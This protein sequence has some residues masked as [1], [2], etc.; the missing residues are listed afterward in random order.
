MTHADDNH[1]ARYTAVALQSWKQAIERLHK[2][3][4]TL[5]EDDLQ[6]RV[7]PGKNRIYYLIGHLAAV[8][9][10]MFPLLGLGERVHPELDEPFLAKP[11]GA[12]ADTLSAADLRKAYADV[13]TKLTAALEQLSPEDW[14]Q[15]HT[16]VSDEDFA[17]NPLRNRLAV[18]HSR[19]GH[20][21]F[22]AGQIR[23]TQTGGE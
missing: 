17:S 10:R 13:N 20:A 8:H 11:D 4:A 9:D 14:L 19:T 3:T 2:L 7:A 12:V 18:L 15:K 6:K 16:A 1:A 5:S 21:M 23:L 22:H